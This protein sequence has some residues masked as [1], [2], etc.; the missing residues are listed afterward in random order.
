[1]FWNLVDLVFVFILDSYQFSNPG[2]KDNTS[3]VFLL[4]QGEDLFQGAY[5]KF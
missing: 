3:V 4:F 2:V 5:Q 1:M